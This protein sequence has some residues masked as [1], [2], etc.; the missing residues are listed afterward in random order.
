M[1]YTE[2]NL[3]DAMAMEVEYRKLRLDAQAKA[4]FD[5][6][7]KLQAFGFSNTIEY[8]NAKK[9]YYIKSSNF[10]IENIFASQ[11]NERI[12]NAINNN[13]ETVLIAIPE[14]TSVYTGTISK[15]NNEFCN[16][17]DIQIINIG[18]EGQ[19]DIVT[20]IEDVAFI[21][22]L[23]QNG[24]GVYLSNRVTELLANVGINCENK[25]GLILYDNKKLCGFAK[26]K[27]QDFY[28]YYWY[29]SFSIYPEINNVLIENPT[30]I[31]SITTIKKNIKRSSV[32]SGVVSWLQ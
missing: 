5:Y 27:I 31:T 13:E 4:E 21:F 23:K 11:I 7:G 14:K 16:N 32:I 3:L 6:H 29:I 12:D 26:R 10:K 19:C 2:Q 9:D 25:N 8:E 30:E 28:V 20:T 1:S 22:V 15:T 18:Y 17:N 24:M